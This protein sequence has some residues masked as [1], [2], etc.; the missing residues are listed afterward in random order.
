ME[1]L[2]LQLVS[3][4]SATLRMAT[5]LVF[6]A[7]AGMFSE[8]SGTIDIGLEGKMLA[9]AFAAACVAVVTGSAW[10]A[11]IGAIIV[12]ILMALLH[13]LACITY[14]GNQVVSGVAINIMAAGLTV[15]L[16]NAW[17][18]RGGQTPDL[19]PDARFMPLRWPGSEAI[20]SIPIV[21]PLYGNVISGHSLLVYIAFLA[22]P[23]G[24]WVL[25]R[26]RFGLRLRAVGEDPKV[27]DTA[28]ISVT[29]LRYRAVIIAGT[30]CGFAGT[31]LA[32]A[33]NAGF[34]PNMT[35]GRGFIALAAM[36]F[37]KWRPWP[38]MFACL[39]F[40]L[41]DAIAI[42]L[43]GVRFPGVGEVPVELIQASPYILTVVL[44][45]GFVGRAMAPHA[46]GHPYVK[47]R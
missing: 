32:I 14:R 34:S 7:M 1:D 25:Y 15:V 31:Y 23:I 28:G 4:L 19:A 44:L 3:I 35:A 42:R 21:G 29:W 39:L 10:V 36:V 22:V 26:T 8:R 5:P 11:L 24:W 2:W 18:G 17:F 12:G 45:A 9:A 38:A 16:G 20:G 27:V 33:Q 47:E 30:L 46:L 13:G 43:Q 37:G 40:G 41:L 6:C